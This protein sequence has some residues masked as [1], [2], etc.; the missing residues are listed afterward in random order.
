MEE[1]SRNA[2]IWKIGVPEEKNME[3]G[4]YLRK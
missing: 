4:K 3:E 1:R 2:N